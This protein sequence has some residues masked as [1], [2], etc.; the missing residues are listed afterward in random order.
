M[1]KILSIFT[2]SIF[3]LTACATAT[4]SP[5]SFMKEAGESG[6]AEVKL[7]TIALQRAADPQV[8][9]FALKMT[10]EHGKANAELAQLAGKK[11]LTLPSDLNASHRGLESKLGKLSG[12]AFDKE[13]MTEMVVDHEKDVKSFQTQAENSTDADVKMFAAKHLPALQQHLKM[14]QDL[15]AKFAPPAK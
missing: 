11:G 3:W 7:A 8:K 9:E 13:Y 1:R 5:E 15:K 4:P 6:M 2:L 10:E 12:E 14:A